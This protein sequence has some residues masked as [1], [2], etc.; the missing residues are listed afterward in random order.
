MI[1]KH[2]KKKG[3]V[4]LVDG[5][6]LYMGVKKERWDID[7]FKFR[8]WLKEK[9]GVDKAYYFIG[10]TTDKHQ[11]L[12]TTLQEAGFILIVKNEYPETFKGADR[13]RKRDNVG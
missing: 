5:Q 13:Y 10:Y 9:Y 7:L 1:Q 2:I 3:N 8:R 6:N 12:Y 11:E 4:A